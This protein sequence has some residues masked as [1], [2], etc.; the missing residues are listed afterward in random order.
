MK[1]LLSI[2]MVLSAVAAAGFLICRCCR[3]HCEP[4]VEN[5]EE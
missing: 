1:K 2:L 5:F 4:M 3:R